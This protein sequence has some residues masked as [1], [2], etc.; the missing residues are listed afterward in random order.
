MPEVTPMETFGR[1]VS[2]GMRMPAIIYICL[3][4]ETD[5]IDHESIALP[6]PDRISHPRRRHVVRK[7]AAVGE[8]LPEVALVLEKNDRHKRRLDD[9]ERSRR[10][11]KRIRHS[12]RQTAPGG[13]VL[14]EVGLPFFIECFRPW[15][16]RNLD[17]VG[18][19]VLQIFTVSSSPNAGQIG[20][21]FARLWDRCREIRLAVGKTRSIRQRHVHPLKKEQCDYDRCCAHRISATVPPFYFVCK[22]TAAE[23]GIFPSFARRGICRLNLV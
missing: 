3:V 4:V 10:H 2:L 22:V 8:N 11:Q 6:L 13:P 16:E 18:C 14:A 12:V 21:S 17:P 9:L 1:M 20:L 5:R 15:L 7:S 23:R 19:D